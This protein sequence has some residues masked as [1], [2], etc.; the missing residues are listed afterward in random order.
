MFLIRSSCVPGSRSFG[1][2]PGPSSEGFLDTFTPGKGS[3]VIF[4]DYSL[5]SE[6]VLNSHR[7]ILFESMPTTS[8]TRGFTY[9]PVRSWPQPS[10][11]KVWFRERV[12]GLLAY[13]ARRGTGGRLVNLNQLGV[14]FTPRSGMRHNLMMTAPPTLGIL[15]SLNPTDEVLRKDRNTTNRR[16]R[17]GCLDSRF[18]FFN[19][20]G[21]A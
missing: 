21:F 19:S 9:S 1:P 20:G 11:K 7:F 2:L 3:I 12:L 16:T 14:R 15:E 4:C 13:P 5:R 18:F 10:T 8:A 6:Y 17:E